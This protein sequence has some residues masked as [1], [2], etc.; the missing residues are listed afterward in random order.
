VEIPLR[1]EMPRL[2]APN[3]FY[4]QEDELFAAAQRR[5]PLRLPRL[6]PTM[7]RRLSDDGSGLA[8]RLVPTK[9]TDFAAV[10]YMTTAPNTCVPNA[11]IRI[12]A[13]K[14]TTNMCD[15][16]RAFTA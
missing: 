2:P 1:E 15:I 13:D 7:E 16:E 8:A 6:R 5:P 4:A 14:V 10:G 12:H 9:A 3:F 11:T